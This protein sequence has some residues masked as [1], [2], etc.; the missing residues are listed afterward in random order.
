[1]FAAFRRFWD[2]RLTL[3]IKGSEGRE[4]GIGS[5][6]VGFHF[7]GAPRF[8][9]QRPQITYFKGFG[10]LWTE[11]RG[12]PKTRNPTL[13]DLTPHSW[14]SDLGFGSR[15]FS[16]RS[17]DFYREP[18]ILAEASFFASCSSRERARKASGAEI[19]RKK[20][21]NCKIP[22][23][24]PP[25]KMWKIPPQNGENYS[26]TTQFCNYSGRIGEGNS[27]VF[28]IFP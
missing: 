6:V 1:M 12:A 3:E 16:Q 28:P 10:D 23:P 15:S 21:K 18:Q 26:E 8:S 5:L 24:S 17:K 13:T 4:W 11:N 7:F 14:P 22:L 27:V 20:G 25:L 9:V 2:L 19:P